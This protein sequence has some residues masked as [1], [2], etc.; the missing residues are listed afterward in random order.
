[1]WKKKRIK[2]NKYGHHSEDIEKQQQLISFQS[3]SSKRNF[4]EQNEISFDIDL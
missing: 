1:M 4:Y 2:K 3:N